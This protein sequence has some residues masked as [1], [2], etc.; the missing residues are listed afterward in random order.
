M[1]L[2]LLTIASIPT[3]I[4][5][6]EAVSAQKKQNAAA[7]RSEKFNVVAVCDV[8]HARV[9]EEVDGRFV[10]LR[11]GKVIILPRQFFRIEARSDL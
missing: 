9:K 5:T 3:V 11:D 10:V 2:G 1:V 6:S 7:K 4:G 8:N